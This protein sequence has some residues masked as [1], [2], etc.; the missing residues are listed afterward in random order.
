MIF[1]A[2]KITIR[3]TSFL[4]PRRCKPRASPEEFALIQEI[5][6]QI[7]ERQNAFFDMEA[8][9]PKKNGYALR[10]ELWRSGKADCLSVRSGVCPAG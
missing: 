6:A 1:L 9:L 8:Y 7:K 5:S 3:N 4:C 2:I 10:W